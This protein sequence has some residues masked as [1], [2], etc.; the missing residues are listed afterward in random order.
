METIPLHSAGVWEW[1]RG[2][3][4]VSVHESLGSIPSRAK[5]KS[6]S[7]AQIAWHPGFFPVQP[8]QQILAAHPLTL[9]SGL[10]PALW[11]L[12]AH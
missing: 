8:T 5:I 11:G 6:N 9:G 1:L 2:Q 12:Q 10:V 7:D 4:A 3:S